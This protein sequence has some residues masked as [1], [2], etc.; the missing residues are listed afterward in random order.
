MTSKTLLAGLAGL[1]G[2]VILSA[3]GTACA[4]TAFLP[5]LYET[6]VRYPNEGPDV[7]TTRE[8]LT[9][10]EAKQESLERRLAEAVQDGNCR[11][12]QR[13]VAGG[14]FTIAGTC[15]SEGVRSSVRQT[16]TYTPTSMAMNM[17]MTMVPAPGAEPVS[18]DM[19]MTSRRLAALC[20]A[21]S[22]ND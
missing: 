5:G 19:V 14:K 11:F 13:S 2:L 8:C 17:R 4:D 16:G 21:D 10:A 18:V 6:R 7:E 12:A 9:A 15:V 20:P 22:D 1:A 3:A